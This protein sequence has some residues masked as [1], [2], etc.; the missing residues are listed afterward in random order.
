MTPQNDFQNIES[1]SRWLQVAPLT[2]YQVKMSEYRGKILLGAVLAVV[3]A[4]GLAGATVLVIPPI[5]STTS[6]SSNSIKTTTVTITTT[7]QTSTS[8]GSVNSQSGQS[9]LL[10]QLTDP[11]VVPFGTTALNLTYNAIT[12][13]VSEPALTT[14]TSTSTVTQG[15]STSTVTSVFSQTQSGVVTTQTVKITP[16]GGSSSVNL[17]RLQNVS[18]TLASAA[19]PNGSTIYS[20]TFNVTGVSITINDTVFAV[21]LATGGSSLL[22]T[23]AQPTMIQGTNAMLVDLTPTV[24][25]TTSGYQMIPSAVGIIRP[26][27]ELT[28]QQQVGHEGNLTNQDQQYLHNAMGQVSASLV[29]LSVS[30]NTTTISVEVNNTGNSTIGLTAIGIQ[31]NFTVQNPG[32]TSNDQQ[33]NNGFDHQFGCYDMHGANEFVFFPN[34][35]VTTPSSG[36]ATGMMGLFNMAAAFDQNQGD[37]HSDNH[38][39]IAAGGCVILTFSSTI[40]IGNHGIVVLP[41]TLAGQQYRVQVIATNSAETML[42]CTLPVSTTSCTPI[43]NN[44]GDDNGN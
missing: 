27:F 7:P 24:V 41:S 31:G 21:S 9:L 10:V 29:S 36:C 22:V 12:L 5:G 39:R 25:N 35:T 32:C 44:F 8:V 23:L 1:Y 4:I 2:V 19:L 6:S 40:S 18:E 42:S 37:F 13:L 3:I 43:H 38:L 30:G 11:P 26:Q 33:G 16:N 28:D 20:V 34:S 14:E 17:L 15:S